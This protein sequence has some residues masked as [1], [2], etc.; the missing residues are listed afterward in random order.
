MYPAFSKPP[1]ST[2]YEV[3]STILPILLLPLRATQS[4]FDTCCKH[5]AEGFEKRE[6]EACS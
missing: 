1:K 6:N 4:P 2:K 5:P 3:R